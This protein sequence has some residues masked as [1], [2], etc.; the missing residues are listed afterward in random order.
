MRT[1]TL[2]MYQCPQDLTKLS[3]YM[4]LHRNIITD[5]C[6][7]LV[8][9]CLDKVI[10]VRLCLGLRIKTNFLESWYLEVVISVIKNGYTLNTNSY[11]LTS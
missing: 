3:H 11:W 4:T 7:I 9:I 6:D 1:I 8:K 10:L 5:S 2:N